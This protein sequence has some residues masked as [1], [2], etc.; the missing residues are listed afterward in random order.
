MAK[1]LSDETG[2]GMIEYAFLLIFIA[3]VAVIA[4]ELVGNATSQIYSNIASTINN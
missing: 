2:A 1:L 4:V 3:L